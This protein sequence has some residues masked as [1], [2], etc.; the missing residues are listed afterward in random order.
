MRCAPRP[1]KIIIHRERSLFSICDGLDQIP[2]PECNVAAGEQ[3][4]CGGCECL[5]IDLDDTG[6]R[7]LDIVLGFKKGEVGLLTDREY[8]GVRFK[9]FGD[10]VVKFR[11]KTPILVKHSFDTAE[12]DLLKSSVLADESSGRA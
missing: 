6:R 8:Y 10:R 9:G 7:Q 2:R 4:G 3:S 11:I 1:A 12:F 5:R